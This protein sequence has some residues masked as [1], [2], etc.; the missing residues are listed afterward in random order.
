MN[1]EQKNILFM[2]RHL[3]GLVYLN[4]QESLL[5]LIPDTEVYQDISGSGVRYTA[6]PHKENNIIAVNIY[7]F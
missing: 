1:N 5:N 3:F 7:T 6:C 4:G 2:N